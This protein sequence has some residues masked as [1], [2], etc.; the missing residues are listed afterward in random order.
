MHWTIEDGS[1]FAF[2]VGHYKSGSTWL[3]NMLSLHPAVRGLAETHVLRYSESCAD[4]RQCTDILFRKV[5]WSGG[6]LRN[7]PRHWLVEFIRPLRAR[8]KSLLPPA[9]RPATRL[10]LSLSQQRS[11]RSCLLASKS[12][13]DYCLRFFCTLHDQLR[14]ERFLI[15][16]T[17]TN[18]FNVPRIKHVFPQAKCI[19][20]Y[21]DGRDVAVSDR[22]FT[23]NEHHREKPLRESAIQW[24]KA[25]RAQQE[26]CDSFDVL[27]VSYEAMLDDPYHAARRLLHYLRL[28]DD[29]SIVENMVRRSS[30]EFT[31]GRR[32][33][34]ERT[35]TFYRK[36]VAGDWRNYFTDEDKRTFRETA[37]D[38]LVHLG[39]EK[40]GNW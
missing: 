12:P 9:D 27:T 30:F 25:M 5:A 37:G 40:D 19:A 6:G 1:R 2:V 36:G 16:K 22:F 32:R 23:R 31:T 35:T 28:P 7:L 14:P 3:I 4:F 10:D 21:R 15:E 17:P 24:C 18:I 29:D 13:D 8:W 39:Y 33:G 38:L 34:E 26:Y 11:L 20:V